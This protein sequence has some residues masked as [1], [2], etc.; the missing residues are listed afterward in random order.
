LD[1]KAESKIGFHDNEKHV[2]GGG[3]KKIDNK[4]LEWKVESKVGSK[5]N[6]KHVPGGGEKKVHIIMICAQGDN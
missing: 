3:A 4:K 1:W 2:A 6:V 5:D